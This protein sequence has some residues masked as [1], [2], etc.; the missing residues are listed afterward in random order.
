MTAPGYRPRHGPADAGRWLRSDAV[1]HLHDAPR[2]GVRLVIAAGL[3]LVA[4]GAS[5]VL[6]AADGIG[7]GIGWA[8]HPGM[9]AA[10]LLLVAGAIVAVSVAHPAGRHHTLIRFVAVL[11]FVAWGLAQLFSGSPAA[12]AL[13]DVAIL[14]FVVDAGYAVVSDA[15]VPRISR[16][17]GN[18]FSR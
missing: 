16:Q 7:G 11:A 1:D 15:G 13:N 14:L 5:V 8:H 6:I 2:P 12:G 4:I 9:S 3:G 10:P 17:A 18:R